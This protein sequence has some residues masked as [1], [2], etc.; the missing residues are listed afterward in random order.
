MHVS[1]WVETL[2]RA[3]LR[4][5][6]GKLKYTST[7]KV[8]SQIEGPDYRITDA[9]LRQRLNKELINVNEESQNIS[10]CK[11]DLWPWQLTSFFAFV[12]TCKPIYWVKTMMEMD[13]D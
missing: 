10:V 8:T 5:K 12:T 1:R 9:E 4:G 2:Q 11:E 3:A 13:M 6:I 7:P